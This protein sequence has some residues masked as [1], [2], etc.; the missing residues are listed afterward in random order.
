MET[1]Y[2]CKQGSRVTIGDTYTGNTRLGDGH[3]FIDYSVRD[4]E[5]LYRQR[6]GLVGMRF[7]HKSVGPEFFYVF[8]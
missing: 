1:M 4:A 7:K 6:H 8:F 5:R 3:L 2:I